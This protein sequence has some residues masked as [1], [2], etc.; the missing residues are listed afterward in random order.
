MKWQNMA[1]VSLICIIWGASLAGS[2]PSTPPAQK[3][4]GTFFQCMGEPRGDHQRKKLEAGEGGLKAV[5]GS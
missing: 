5:C 1:L 4:D 3:H 2:S